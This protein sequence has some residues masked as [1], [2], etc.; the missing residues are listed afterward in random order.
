MKIISLT[1]SVLFL[2]SI[3]NADIITSNQPKTGFLLPREEFVVPWQADGNTEIN[4]NIDP[5]LHVYLPLTHT[6][7]RVDSI[8]I[9][10]WEYYG[11]SELYTLGFYE[12]VDYRI[13]NWQE[14]NWYRKRF[15]SHPIEEIPIS[16]W[17][18]LTSE[19]SEPSVPSHPTDPLE[20]YYEEL[21]MERTH[22][23][24]PEPST[25]VLFSILFIPLL[26]KK[27]I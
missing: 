4:Q 6:Y 17:Q 24:T 3:V 14:A 9:L 23:H 7:K 25:L 20:F 5:P 2:C 21:G 8:S 22:I 1:F 12:D 16:E 19:P 26:R 27:R 10:P 18:L 15:K 11:I 13:K